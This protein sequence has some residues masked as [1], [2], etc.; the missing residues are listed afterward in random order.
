MEECTCPCIDCIEGNH[1]GGQYWIEDESGED[2][3]VGE[4]GYISIEQWHDMGIVVD[5]CDCHKC[6]PELYEN[7]DDLYD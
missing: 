7:E 6:R 3:L 1:C 4:C 2:I 5:G